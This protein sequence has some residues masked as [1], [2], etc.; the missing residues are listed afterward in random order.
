MIFLCHAGSLFLYCMTVYIFGDVGLWSNG[1][2]GVAYWVGIVSVPVYLILIIYYRYAK[3]KLI[4]REYA[5]R[6]MN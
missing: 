2:F 6:L 3:S 4:S 5:N 1:G